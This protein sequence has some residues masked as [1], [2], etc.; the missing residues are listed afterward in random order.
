MKYLLIL[1]ISI[2]V[3]AKQLPGDASVS[4][5]LLDYLTDVYLEERIQ[6]YKNPMVRHHELAGEQSRAIASEV[7]SALAK[8]VSGDEVDRLQSKLANQAQRDGARL[9]QESLTNIF[10]PAQQQLK[11]RLE[12]SLRREVLIG[13]RTTV[14]GAML[15]D[16]RELMFLFHEAANNL[17]HDLEVRTAWVM[18]TPRPEFYGICDYAEGWRVELKRFQCQ[19]VLR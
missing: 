7:N 12:A 6:N 15:G 4:P 3:S 18:G 5:T 17:K 16:D 8:G 14:E 9:L 1:L 2:E 13:D 10:W 11:R 19:G